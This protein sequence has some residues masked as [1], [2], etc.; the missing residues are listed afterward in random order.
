VERKC[1]AGAWIE[2]IQINKLLIYFG[3]FKKYRVSSKILKELAFSLIK[4]YLFMTKTYRKFI[5]NPHEI[6]FESL[7]HQH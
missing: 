4:K 1:S 7:N 2:S 5:C 3:R 6:Q